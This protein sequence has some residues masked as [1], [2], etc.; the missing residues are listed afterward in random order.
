M[1]P[2]PAHAAGCDFSC[3]CL[4]AAESVDPAAD[5]TLLKAIEFLININTRRC[6]HVGLCTWLE[7]TDA[8]LC[9]LMSRCAMTEA[10]VLGTEFFPSC[11]AEKLTVLARVDPLTGCSSMAKC[12][13][14][15]GSFGI[16]FSV[17]IKQKALKNSSL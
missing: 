15:I 3:E 11:V 2:E 8:S 6:H 7:L 10:P 5:H 9:A 14:L 13:D 17:N 12:K 1:G 4:L 16:L